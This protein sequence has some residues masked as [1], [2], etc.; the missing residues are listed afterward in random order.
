METKNL[1]YENAVRRLEQIISQI[2]NNELDID[3]LGASF[4]EARELL[5][6]CKD[7]LF[8]TDTEIKKLLDSFQE[9]EN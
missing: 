2:E 3:R 7:K 9:K 8:S 4:K 6:F 1:T 5:A